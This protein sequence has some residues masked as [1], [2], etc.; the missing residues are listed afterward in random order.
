MAQEY[1]YAD[2]EKRLSFGQYPDVGLRDARE[3]RNAARKHLLVFVRPGE[4]RNA[5]WSE[6]DLAKKEWRYEIKK[7]KKSGVREHI[8]PLSTQAVAILREMKAISGNGRKVFPGA[9]G[10]GRPLS[11]NALLAAMRRMEIPAE[12]MTTHGLRATARALLDE[13]LGFRTDVIERQLAHR[14]TDANDEAYNRTKHLAE[15]HKMMQAWADYLD[16][17]KA[18]GGEVISFPRTA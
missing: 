3:R 15:R 8:V 4:L 14:V 9:R 5:E 2:R 12:E 18:K 6:F 17:L 16:T 10:G 1:R 11:D 13:T 7:T